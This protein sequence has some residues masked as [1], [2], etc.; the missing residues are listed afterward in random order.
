MQQKRIKSRP[1][2]SIYKPTILTLNRKHIFC[3]FLS[4]T[5]YNFCADIQCRYNP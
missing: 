2:G 3:L 5:Y 4:H 1:T